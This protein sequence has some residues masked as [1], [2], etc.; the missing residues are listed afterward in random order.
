MMQTKEASPTSKM[1][2]RNRLLFLLADPVIWYWAA[3]L[4]T[5][6]LFLHSLFVAGPAWD[7]PEEFAKLKSQLL[8]AGTFLTGKTDLSFRSLPGDYAYYGVGSVLIPYALSHLV[9]ILW[10]KQPVHSYA[11]SYSVFLHIQTFV[12]AIGA[13]VYVRRL[14]ALVT[15]NRDIGLLA[16]LTLLL[17]P[18]WIGYGFIDYKD[19]PVAT[20]VIAATY[21]AVAYYKD[22]LSRTSACFF[23]SL[24]FI[25]IQKVAAIPLALPACVAV[26]IAV[27]R[28]P[29]VR[30]LSIL[31]SQAVICLCLLYVATPPAWPA[32]VRFVVASLVY[33][34]RH[35]WLGCTLTAGHCVGR[36]AVD[37]EGY[38]V[39]KYLGL[40][41]GVKL[42]VPIWVGL[43]SAIF[44]YLRSFRQLQVGQHLLVAALCW[45]I[46]ALTIRGSTLYDGIRHVL[47]LVPI[48]VALIFVVIPATVWQR[49]RW[50]LAIYFLLLAIDSL[51]LQPYQ[52]VWFNEAARFF[53]TEKNFETDY[54]GYSL[55]E[56]VSRARDERESADWIVSPP[57]DGNPSHLVE[58]FAAKRYVSDIK[59]IPPGATYYVVSGT[60]MN[61]QPPKQCDRVEY[62]TRTEL[63]APTPLRLSFVAKCQQMR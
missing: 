49:L 17:T 19:I 45:P 57:G 5:T 25:G 53:A 42:P 2:R 40:W 36:E 44:L 38:S 9:D 63:L 47:F 26:A 52:Y 18:F 60:R 46:A 22:G 31:A 6:C 59:S 12:C 62:V 24:L 8:F 58:V 30:R 13:V 1:D 48:V 55:R 29:S 33:S 4:L 37:A 32:P 56:A 3:I 61:R 20:G 7:E 11:H 35:L 41:Y 27:L 10:L 15:E 51:K 43:L 21:Y 28:Q 39:L 34:S 16:G 50:G 14:V 54:W 23:L